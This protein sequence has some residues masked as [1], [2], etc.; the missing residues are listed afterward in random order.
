MALTAL[1]LLNGLTFDQGLGTQPIVSQDSLYLN[2]Y[3]LKFHGCLQSASLKAFT[4]DTLQILLYT[5]FWV[6]PRRLN[7]NANVSEYS[8]CSIFIGG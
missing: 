6:I 5:F 2:F 1:Q 4:V 7:L 8:V 3:L